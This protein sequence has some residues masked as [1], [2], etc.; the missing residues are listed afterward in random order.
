MKETLQDIK[1]RR[2]C[3][4][5]QARQI[6]D[7]ELATVLEAGTWAATGR[8]AQSPLIIAL[9]DKETIARLSRMNAEILGTKSDPFYGAPTVLVVLADPARPTWKEDASLVIGNLML[10]AH[11]IGLGSCWI[12][13]A[14]EEFASEEGKKL[15]KRW[16]IEGEY[17]GVGHCILG[18]AAEGGEAPAAPRKSGY[19]VYVK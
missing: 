19:V 18:Y 9:Q 1:T 13:R 3:R 12:H 15:L 17:I 5:Y 2:S 14:A 10:A 7:E 6:T 11:A 8:G 4:K 16:G